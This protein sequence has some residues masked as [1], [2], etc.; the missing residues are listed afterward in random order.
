MFDVDLLIRRVVSGDLR[1]Y[2]SEGT[3]DG[4][5]V[6]DAILFTPKRQRVTTVCNPVQW[7]RKGA[8]GELV[9]ARWPEAKQPVEAFVLNWAEAISRRS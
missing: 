7:K 9:D 6:V 2:S 3:R 4:R 1:A 5:R 8:Q